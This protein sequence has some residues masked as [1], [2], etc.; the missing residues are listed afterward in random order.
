MDPYRA[1]VIYWILFVIIT[2][3]LMTIFLLTFLLFFNKRLLLTILIN[4]EFLTIM[5]LKISFVFS[6]FFL[7]ACCFLAF[8][9]GN[10]TLDNHDHLWVVFVLSCITTYLLFKY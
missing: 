7:V 2:T 4:M 1:Y 3:G 8:V 10:T 9:Q 6:V 5:F